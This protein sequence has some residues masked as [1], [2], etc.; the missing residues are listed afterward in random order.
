MHIIAG[1]HYKRNLKVPKGHKTRP[2]FSR[3]KQSLFNILQD[4]IVDATFLDLFAGAGGMGL[5]AISRGAKEVIMV[6]NDKLA[7][8]TIKENI[9][10]LQEEESC[11]VI[12][13][14]VFEALKRFV[15]KGS[16]F[17]IIFADPPY[18]DEESCL[19]LEVLKFVDQY[20]ILKP[21]GHLFLEDSKRASKHNIELTTLTLK[22]KREMGPAFLKDYVK[23]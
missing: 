4:E 1:K 2:T 12:V 15:K 21:G 9:A 13:S 3:L 20:P 11:K 18:G 17:D 10:L 19:S 23:L 8:A 16:S 7:I 14:D 22:S 6:E 5:E